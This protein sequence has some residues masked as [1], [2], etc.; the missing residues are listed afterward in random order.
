ML[1]QVAL[2]DEKIEENLFAMLDEET[3]SEYVTFVI[4]NMDI[5]FVCVLGFNVT[6]TLFHFSVSPIRSRELKN[7]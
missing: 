7:L 1:L 2:I 3:D 4:L 6:C 5:L